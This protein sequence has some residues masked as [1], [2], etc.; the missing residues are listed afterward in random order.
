[1]E[2]GS[3]D[4]IFKLINQLCQQL[5]NDYN[6][7]RT[8]GTKNLG[9]KTVRVLR[10][11]AFE[12]LLGKSPGK[13]LDYDP[14]RELTF[15][16]FDMRISAQT[17]FDRDRCEELEKCLESLLSGQTSVFRTD[18]GQAILIFL[19]SLKN[20]IVNNAES[21]VMVRKLLEIKIIIFCYSN[22]CISGLVP[23]WILFC[24]SKLL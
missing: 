12:I 21:S 4:S 6:K 24:A 15:H 20:S 10:K 11:S 8:Y 22:I 9:G 19:L 2:I 5:C 1:M 13:F 23:I 18:H 16:Q 3:S 7:K 14:I 17:T